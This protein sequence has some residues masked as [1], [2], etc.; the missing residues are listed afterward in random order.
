MHFLT[1][2][3]LLSQCPE[4]EHATF[5]PL[6]PPN[7]KPSI[8]HLTHST[9][10]VEIKEIPENRI[11]ADGAITNIADFTLAITHADCQVALIVD[12]KHLCIGAIHAGWRGLFGGIYHN[13]LDLFIKRGSR[14]EDLLI[15]V[16]PSLGVDASEFIHY[17]EEIPQEYHRYKQASSHFDLKQIALAQ[18]LARGVPEKQIEI[19]PI[20]TFTSPE[21]SS[22]RRAKRMNAPTSPRNISIIKIL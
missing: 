11:E 14:I 12:P 3:S 9:K 13:A 17:K 22:Y 18:F 10:V 8:L 2:S 20:C 15:Y 5:S 21:F 1:Q 7:L 16:T 6:A 19:S 4:I